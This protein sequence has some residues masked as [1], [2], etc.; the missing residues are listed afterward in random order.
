MLASEVCARQHGNEAPGRELRLETAPTVRFPA[1]VA[2]SSSP[3]QSAQV[4]GE[5]YLASQ[6]SGAHGLAL[7]PGCQCALAMP[8][9]VFVCV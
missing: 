8:R 9:L 2:V 1:R 6:T 4:G 3:V 5:R 7:L